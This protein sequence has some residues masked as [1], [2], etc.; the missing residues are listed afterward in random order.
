MANIKKCQFG[1]NKLEFV[2][3]IVGSN[4]LEVDPNKIKSVNEWPIHKNIRD[5]RSF[6]GFAT[7]YRKF[8][9]NFA[10]IA[11]PLTNLLKKENNK[12]IWKDSVNDAFNELKQNL[13]CAPIL[14]FPDF[15][16][17]LLLN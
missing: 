17:S 10:L 4:G 7:Y 5:L 9:K 16:K 13:V 1:L 6:L 14:K 11:A 3:H 8:I 15:K 2:G 12:F